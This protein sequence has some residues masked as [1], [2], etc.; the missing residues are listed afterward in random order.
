MASELKSPASDISPGDASPGDASPGDASPGD[1]SLAQAF[2][3]QLAAVTGGIAPDDYVQAWWDW[4]LNLSKGTDKQAAIVQSAAKAMADNF[5]YAL[6]AASGKAPPAAP[7]DKQFASEAWNIWPFNVYARS[8]RNWSSV[9]Q[10]ALSA[11]PGVAPRSEQLV[12]FMGKQTLDAL[13]PA[14]HLISN[15]ELLEM[16]RAQ[17]GHNLIRGFG[18]WL[19]DLDR[20]LRK[21]PLSGAEKFKV[22]EQL[23]VTPGKVVLRNELMELIQYR[24]STPTVHAEPI[25]IAPAWIMKYYILDLSPANSMV[26]YLVEKGH[27]VFMISWKNPNAA[28]RHLGMEDYVQRGFVAALDAVTSI[29]PNQKVHAVGY[30]IGG[31]L[32]S[33][34]AARLAQNFDQRLASVTLLAAQTDFSEP[35]ELS[36]FISPSQL[37]ML[38]AVMKKAGVLT[39]DKMAAAFALLRSNDLLWAPAINNYVKG[40]RDE[41][42][43]LMAWNADGTRMPWRMHSDYLKFLYLQ[44][45]LA[46]GEYSLAGR[47]IDLAAIRVPMVVVGT[48]TDHV[49][50][51][52]SVY[53]TR[54]L[55]RSSDYTFLLTS[56]GHNAG[57]VSGPAHPKRRFRELTWTDDH[58]NL[59]AEQWLE[60]ASLHQ[61]SWWPWWEQWLSSHST[62]HDS[63]LPIIGNAAAGFGVQGDAPGEYVLQR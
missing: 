2:K 13:N 9:M 23:A 16:T 30:C 37:S 18:N 57:I 19:H 52:R 63:P 40:K 3:V 58:S 54:G 12:Q 48:E 34:A 44:N 10:E 55:T 15:P 29:V 21:Q 31:T 20:T 50:P 36:L 24:A 45:D 33:I 26:R 27:T 47:K 49:A 6:Q 14:N 32:L 41:I 25:L 11:V 38:E 59:S 35:G 1:K 8:F 5:A 17:S 7:G 51:W 56:G 43:D 39:S 42:N 60:K 4:Y 53:K 62:A 28:D 61:G 46:K 22:G